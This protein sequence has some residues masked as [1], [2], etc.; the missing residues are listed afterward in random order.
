MH[1]AEELR[2]PKGRYVPEGPLCNSHDRQVVVTSV[3]NYFG[4]PKDRQ[5]SCRPCGPQ[6]F[7]WATVT[8][9]WRS[10]LLH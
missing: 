6:K 8:P 5:V 4:G 3:W 9:T 2:G 1:F 10:G 7:C